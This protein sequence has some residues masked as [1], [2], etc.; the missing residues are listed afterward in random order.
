MSF[1]IAVFIGFLSASST[2]AAVEIDQQYIAPP[3]VTESLDHTDEYMAQ[4][5]TTQH[6]GS[7]ASIGVQVDIF[8][9]NA[10]PQSRDGITDGLHLQL[11]HITSTGEPDLTR[12]LASWVIDPLNIPF[13]S[14]AVPITSTDLSAYNLQVSA[15]DH[16]AIVINT[17][18][19]DTTHPED[20]NYGW[21]LAPMGDPV[22]GGVFYVYSPL[23]TPNWIY[24]RSSNDPTLTTDGGFQVLVNT[25]PEPSSVVLML[26][27]TAVGCSRVNRQR[28]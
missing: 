25:V 23:L 10:P 24:M 16:L 8:G 2:F 15:G 4:T 14:N 20:R 12:V 22:P 1:K 17:S 11:T 26:I 6:S 13:Q 5:F 27:G 18:Y 19:L 9:I 7:I 28:L 3:S 21:Q